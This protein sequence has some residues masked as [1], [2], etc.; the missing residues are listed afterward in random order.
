MKKHILFLLSFL[1]LL[2]CSII[3][4]QKSMWDRIP[5]DI[6]LTKPYQRFEWFYKQRAFPYDTIPKTH[7]LNVIRAEKEKIEKN[8]NKGSSLLQWESLGPDGAALSSGL[9]WYWGVLS[10]RVR[11]L[12]IHPTD[13]LTVY[14]GAASGGIWKTT[15]GGE[16]WQELSS[17]L[18]SLTHGAIAIDPNNPEIIYAGSGE[19]SYFLIP[20]KYSGRGL[21]KST[22]GGQMDLYPEYNL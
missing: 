12:A 13:P 15:N 11:G 18:A 5:E 20:N 4:Q 9:G 21:F 6:K 14:I 10:G 3:A 16:N 8:I 17:D 2:P 19:A 22:N 1:F 7:Y